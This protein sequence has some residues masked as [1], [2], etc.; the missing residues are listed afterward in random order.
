MA[1]IFLSYAREDLD[2]AEVM[3]RAFE[4][5]GLVGLVRSAHTSS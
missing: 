1:D 5:A 3:V 2:R 4:N